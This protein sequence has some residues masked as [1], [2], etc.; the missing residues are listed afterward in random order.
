MFVL[1]ME[2]LCVQVCSRATESLR[3]GTAFT[4]AS[5]MQGKFFWLS[6]MCEWELIFTII[7]VD[8]S[9]ELYL[10]FVVYWWPFPYGREWAVYPGENCSAEAGE[11]VIWHLNA[12]HSHCNVQETNITMRLAFSRLFKVLK[13]WLKNVTEKYKTIR[14]G[15]T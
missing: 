1:Q 7:K 4:G 10:W 8:D 15:I 5:H 6:M 3:W 12:C 13:N 11:F 14:C 9:Q 2:Q